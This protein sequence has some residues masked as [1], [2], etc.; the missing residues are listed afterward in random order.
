MQ[1]RLKNYISFFKVLTQ[2]KNKRSYHLAATNEGFRAALS[3]VTT[4]SALCW[5]NLLLGNLS[6]GRQ[7]CL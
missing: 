2:V 6:V 3:V 4:I 7:S 5:S 1:Q